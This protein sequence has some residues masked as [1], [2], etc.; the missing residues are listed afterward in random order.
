MLK[1]FFCWISIQ[2][3][4]S[5][6][7]FV[8][9]SHSTSF[10]EAIESLKFSKN[11][12]DDTLKFLRRLKRSSVVQAN[13]SSYNNTSYVEPN[14]DDDDDFGDFYFGPGMYF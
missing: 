5:Y 6:S 3:I 7:I 9:N 8:V 2:L 4:L 12:A 14:Y 13:G 10:E 1:H 11:Y